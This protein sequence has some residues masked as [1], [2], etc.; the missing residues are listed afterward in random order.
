MTDP[1]ERIINRAISM[2][3]DDTARYAKMAHADVQDI[4][5][6]A[7]GALHRIFR[8]TRWFEQELELV[9]RQRDAAEQRVLELEKKEG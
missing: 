6:E 2:L 1:D 7:R 4:R 5:E 8:K 3:D 9:R